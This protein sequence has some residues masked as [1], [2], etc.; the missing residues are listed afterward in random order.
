MVVLRILSLVCGAAL[1]FGAAGSCRHPSTIEG[2]YTEQEAK[3][4]LKIG[5]ERS[6]ISARFGQ[7]ISD[8]QTGEGGEVLIYHRPFRTRATAPSPG[9]YHFTGFSV[10][11]RDNKLVR[12]EP[13][14]ANT[15]DPQ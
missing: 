5:V 11:L 2:D 12:W 3:E 13:I 6:A 14:T 10:Y 7:P 1:C 4:F 8:T 9:K 15:S